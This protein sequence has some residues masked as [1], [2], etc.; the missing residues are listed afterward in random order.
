MDA[1]GDGFNECVPWKTPATVQLCDGRSAIH[2]TID[3]T[4]FT[5]ASNDAAVP[6]H[7]DMEFTLMKD[8]GGGTVEPIVDEIINFH[9][10]LLSE[11]EYVEAIYDN[12]SGT[13]RVELPEGEW[14]ANT[15]SD[16]EL[17][18]WEEFELTEDTVGVSWILRRSI[19]VTGQILVETGKEEAPE[20]GVPNIE[21]KFQ[22]GGITTSVQT[23]YGAESGNFSV[24][25]PEGIEVN[26]TTISIANQMSNG[27][28][29]IVTDDVS[30]VIL[31]VE[32]GLAVDGVLYLFE[33][34]TAYSPNVPGFAEV[35][36]HGYQVDRGV[37]WYFDIDPETGRFSQK[38]MEGNWTLDVSDER[39]N[40]DEIQLEVSNSNIEQLSHVE[41]IANPD[42]VTVDISA[43][44]DHSLD[45]NSSNGTFVNIDFAFVPISGGGVGTR[46]N[47]TAEEMSDGQILTSLQPGVYTI[48]IDAQDKVNGSDFDTV[49]I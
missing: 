43:F 49:L 23:S 14:I 22:W 45:G 47:I 18:L 46:L 5:M 16:G 8:L 26:M 20:E 44:L 41:L 40:V 29:F 33:N 30:P 6:M 35:Q 10:M 28:N 2:A 48:A 27:T 9:S 25:L 13:Y 39:L 7:F 31:H 1:D 12:E 3:P 4:N 21:V 24:F 38:L 37:H 42:N 15:S 36:L 17:M 34:Q 32:A 11:D 19:N